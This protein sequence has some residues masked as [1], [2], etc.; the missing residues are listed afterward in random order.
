MTIMI[1][2]ETL[3]VGQE[4][5]RRDEHFDCTSIALPRQLSFYSTGIHHAAFRVVNEAKQ[6][7]AVRLS[8]EPQEI[9]GQL[10]GDFLCP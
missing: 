7:L 3:L 6:R 4:L 8:G 2:R 10:I 1:A 9:N 5:F